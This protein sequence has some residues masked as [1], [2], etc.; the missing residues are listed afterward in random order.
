LNKLIADGIS[1]NKATSEKVRDEV[2]RAE[3][4]E[5]GDLETASMTSPRV[6]ET[7]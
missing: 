1:L 6:S 2:K 5:E 4:R 3:G 7:P